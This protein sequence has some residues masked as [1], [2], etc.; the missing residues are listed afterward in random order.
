MASTWSTKEIL[1]RL[2]R[3]LSSLPL[4]EACRGRIVRTWF[5]IEVIGGMD[6]WVMGGARGVIHDSTIRMDVDQD[7]G[8]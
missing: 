3:V 1:L 2:H 4:D 7:T 5:D 8:W 6:G